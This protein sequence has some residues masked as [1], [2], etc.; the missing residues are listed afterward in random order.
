MWA[1][2]AAALLWLA[3]AESPEPGGSAEAGWPDLE[4]LPWPNPSFFLGALV[5]GIGCSLLKSAWSSRP[6]AQR[7][8]P[9]GIVLSPEEIVASL[10]LQLQAAESRKTCGPSAVKEDQDSVERI[11]CNCREVVS[12]KIAVYVSGP[13]DNDGEQTYVICE[14]RG[15]TAGPPLL[16]GKNYDGTYRWTAPAD[17]HIHFAMYLALAMTRLSG[18]DWSARILPYLNG[19]SL[20][21]YQAALRLQDWREVWDTLLKPFGR[22]RAVYLRLR[23]S[24]RAPD[25]FFGVQAK[26][27]EPV[28][29]EDGDDANCNASTTKTQATPAGTTSSSEDEVAFPDFAT[30]D[31]FESS[32]SDSLRGIGV[33]STIFS[34][35]WQNAEIP[36]SNTFIN[37]PPQADERGSFPRS[38]SMPDA[39]GRDS[40]DDLTSTSTGPSGHSNS[41]GSSTQVHRG[42]NA[43]RTSSQV[44]MREIWRL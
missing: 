18:E 21:R 28:D 12:Q 10:Q 22:Q 42:G 32:G 44:T 23:K 30:D 29:L 13:N 9:K 41:S 4:H 25:I 17:R 43:T 26:L 14:V 36:Q 20:V 33:G 6:Q 38:N 16:P 7:E 31:G 15:C 2:A 27:R 37:F 40:E 11:V 1:L 35:Y 3:Q 34:D 5:A 19:N 39:V 24:A 8:L